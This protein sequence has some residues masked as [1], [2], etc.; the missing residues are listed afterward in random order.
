M[1]LSHKQLVYEMLE[2]NANDWVDGMELLRPDVGG[3][4][5]ARRLRELRA[6]GHNI[7]RRLHPDQ[8][9]GMWQYRLILDEPPSQIRMFD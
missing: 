1:G 3:S 2:R 7:Q 9:H 8:S 5:G 6:D 4:E